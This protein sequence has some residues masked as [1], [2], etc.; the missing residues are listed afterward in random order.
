MAKKSDHE[1][2]ANEE[3]LWT[4]ADNGEKT[5]RAKHTKKRRMKNENN[6]N[7]KN[8]SLHHHRSR[9]RRRSR[10]HHHQHEHRVVCLF[11]LIVHSTAIFYIFMPHKA[12]TIFFSSS[13]K[14]IASVFIPFWRWCFLRILIPPTAN[15]FVY[16]C[17]TTKIK[18]NLFLMHNV[19]CAICFT[20]LFLL[21]DVKFAWRSVSN[22]NPVWMQK[23]ELNLG[24]FP[25]GRFF[26][27][28][29]ESFFLVWK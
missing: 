20:V 28:F 26:L 2:S 14:W 25:A 4:A 21:F 15:V 11:G 3:F 8:G 23:N 12:L 7:N 22:E 13:L 24:R 1:P 17:K 29:V 6:H 9:R 19:F 18:A 10:R 27:I 5:K 16:K